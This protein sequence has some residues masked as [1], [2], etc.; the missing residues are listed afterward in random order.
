MLFYYPKYFYCLPVNNQPEC[1][2][3]VFN[4]AKLT[5]DFVS[6]CQGIDNLLLIKGDVSEFRISFSVPG[7]VH[8]KA[9]RVCLL[10]YPCFQ[11]LL[12]NLFSQLN[13]LF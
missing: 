12:Q 7:K 2:L 5:A 4:A 6:V 9:L 1:S 10:I 3:S 13:L 11:I 8:L